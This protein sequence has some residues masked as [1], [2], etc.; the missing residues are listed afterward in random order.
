ML[1]ST[2]VDVFT[3]LGLGLLVGLQK[4]RASSP[5]AGLKTFALM[6]LIGAVSALLA[7]NLGGWIVVG[8]LIA[9]AAM[10]VISNVVMLRAG[11]QQPGQ[12]TESAV[13]LTFLIGALCV[14]GPREVAIVLGAT[15]AMLLHLRE[16]LKDW[17]ARLTDRD[18]RAFM[19][20]IVIWLV[21]LPV[22]PDETFGPYDVLNPRQIWLMVVLIVGLNVAGY[23]A[24]RIMGARAG[25]L[26]AGVLGGVISSTATT[27]S[28][29]RQSKAAEGTAQTAAVV[30]WIASGVVFVRILLEIGAVAPSF[31]PVA[32]T[33]IGVMLALFVV[34]AAVV[35][36]SATA[37]GDSPLEP[38]NPSELKPALLFGGLYALVLFAVAAAQDLLGNVGLFA[39]AF[40]SGLTDIDAITLS[41]SRLVDTGVV[42]QGTGWRLILVAAMSNMVFKFGLAVSLGSPALAKRL[43]TLFAVAVA[44]GM[45]L[46]IFSP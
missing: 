10:L 34:L 35:W 7:Q 3:A 9:V 8:S 36:R 15:T 33:P 23:A 45:G 22:L 4:E 17:V 13:V 41:T 19:Q 29:A 12:T 28:Y 24:F 42:E 18:V 26:L 2:F 25:T 39:T 46:V 20:F 11:S 27:M 40:L 43:G 6:S 32:A 37:P 1:S 44:V 21:V 14:V 5:M 16:E 30:V 38:G 31:L